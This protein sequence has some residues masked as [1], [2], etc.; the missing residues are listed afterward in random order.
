MTRIVV[1]LEKWFLV[2]GELVIEIAGGQLDM[3]A[4]SSVD[5]RIDS[6]HHLHAC[7]LLSES[8]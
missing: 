2:V 4:T 7:I 3:A 8:S 5:G 6:I 1:L